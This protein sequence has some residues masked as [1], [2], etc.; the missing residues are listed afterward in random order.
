MSQVVTFVR[1]HAKAKYGGEYDRAG[2]LE[3]AGLRD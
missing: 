1:Q 3:A 2:A